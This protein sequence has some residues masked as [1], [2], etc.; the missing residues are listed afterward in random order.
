[1]APTFPASLAQ[2][3]Q[4]AVLACKSW[5]YFAAYL[6][7]SGA[8]SLV[9][10]YDFIAPEAYLVE[11]IVEGWRHDE[12]ASAIRIRAAQAY[13]KYQKISEKS[14]RRIFGAPKS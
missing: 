9:V 8:Q 10:T 7:R 12:S 3:R 1:M 14:A 5:D 2:G 4:A 6:N 11:G 13:A